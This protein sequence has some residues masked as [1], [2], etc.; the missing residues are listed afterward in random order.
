MAAGFDTVVGN[1]RAYLPTARIDGVQIQ[2]MMPPGIEMVVGMVRDRDFGP[3]L[4]LGLGGVLVEVIRD[5][6][7]APVPVDRDAARRMIDRLKGKAI[8][9]GVRG[10]PPAD[11]EALVDLLMNVSRLIEQAGD[12][13]VE[14]DLNPVIL[15]RRAGLCSGRRAD[16]WQGGLVVAIRIERNGPRAG[17]VFDKPEKLNAL[18][19]EERGELAALFAQL[20]QDDTV[21]VVTLQGAG[22][23]F[24]SG[25]DVS[26]MGENDLISARRRMQTGVHPLI[27][28]LC[29]LE[30][31]VIAGIR[32]A[33]SGIGWGMALASDFVIASETAKFSFVFVRRGLIPDARFALHARA[34][35]RSVS[36]QGDCLHRPCGSCR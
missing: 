32:G 15:T 11:I 16:R 28:N 14:I 9:H 2:K 30:K 26:R 33:A 24:C 25:A 22:K 23:A 35:C 8:L 12:G 5:V 10:K 7:F 13:I 19:P 17:I 4:M 34:A 27:R 21:R 3:V 31:P 36:G 29:A 6:A 1:A 20:Q 18:T